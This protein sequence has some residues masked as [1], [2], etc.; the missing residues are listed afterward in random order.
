MSIYTNNTFA[1]SSYTYSDFFAGGYFNGGEGLTYDEALAGDYPCYGDWYNINFPV[2][3][4]IVGQNYS[5]QPTS[6]NDRYAWVFTNDDEYFGPEGA[7]TEVVIESNY[8]ILGSI[9]KV[10]ELK[11]LKLGYTSVGDILP[12]VDI[13]VKDNFSNKETWYNCKPFVDP[14]GH[15]VYLLRDLQPH[16]YFKFKIYWTNTNDKY[17][18]SLNAISL[19][20]GSEESQTR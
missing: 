15:T 1:V 10:R 16:V 3:Q 6:P 5:Y 18:K 9:H 14:N 13:C 19:V 11:S 4:L 20:V 8:L 17:I 7:G 12:K 2:G